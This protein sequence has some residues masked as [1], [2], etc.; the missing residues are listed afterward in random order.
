ME[1][2]E[3]LVAGED[4]GEQA[5][6]GGAAGVGVVGEQGELG[7]GEGRDEV[8]EL[9]AAELV[10][11]DDD[12]LFF[13]LD[14]GAEAGELVGLGDDGGGFGGGVVA[15]EIGGERAVAELLDAGGKPWPGG[16]V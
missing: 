16:G 8:G 12:E 1:L 6:V 7:V 10:A 5:H 14:G 9:A 15:G 2:G 11:D 13:G 3:G 4:V